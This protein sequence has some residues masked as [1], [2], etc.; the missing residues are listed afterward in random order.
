MYD[1]NAQREQKNHEEARMVATITKAW[2][3][4]SLKGLTPVF[5]KWTDL[6]TRYSALDH[7]DACYWYNERATLSV[8]AAA[9]WQVKGWVGLEEY[10]TRKSSVADPADPEPKYDRHGRC[11]LYVASKRGGAQYACEAKQA[12]QPMGSARI[13][14]DLRVVRAKRR[15]ASTAASEL[16]KIEAA[17][18][19]ALTL[20]IPTLA[21][22]G[23]KVAL[24]ESL[25]TDHVEA[26]C[27]KIQSEFSLHA[28]ACAFPA[29][30]RMLTN[31]DARRYFPGVAILVQE[32]KKG[33][34]IK[35]GG[36]K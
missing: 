4:Q 3:C 5:R 13:E 35:N 29:H 20:C 23:R 8:L 26:W 31:D 25:I 17:H 36:G 6:V 22:Y 7:D 11:D 10:S 24:T 15:A 34:R 2:A 19:L 16:T 27:K 1:A 32:R 28:F 9:A 18:R 30:S 33:M 21:I 14:D 12:W